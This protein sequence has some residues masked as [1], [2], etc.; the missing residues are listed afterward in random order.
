MLILSRNVNK[1]IDR[2]SVFDCHLS[3]HWR[4]MT[5]ETPFLSVFDPRSSTVDYIFDFHLLGGLV[6][7]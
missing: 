7:V 4:Q 1:K 6:K 2:N 5:I 3:P